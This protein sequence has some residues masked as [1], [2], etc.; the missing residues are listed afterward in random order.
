MEYSYIVIY[1]VNLDSMKSNFRGSFMKRFLFITITAGLLF[2]NVC[3]SQVSFVVENKKPEKVIK[4]TKNLKLYKPLRIKFNKIDSRFYLVDTHAPGVKVFDKN[5]K[6][7]KSIGSL[8]SAPGQFNLPGDV[9]FID[10][11]IIIVDSFNYRIQIFDMDMNYISSFKYGKYGVGTTEVFA[12][13]DSKGRIY[14]NTVRNGALFDVYDI[15]GNVIKS[16][17]ESLENKFEQRKNVKLDDKTHKKVEKIDKEL[18]NTVSYCIDENDDLFCVFNGFPVLRKYDSKNELVFEVSLKDIP[19]IQN[20]PD[21]SNLTS[22]NTRQCFNQLNLDEKYL[23]VCLALK[24][25]PLYILDKD[26]GKIL[27]KLYLKHENN[28]VFSGIDTSQDNFIYAVD[29]ENK[30]VLRYKK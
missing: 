13:V 4:S 24:D 25:S 26:T 14:L 16:F 28:T 17:G 2:S 5:F 18:L 15:E 11:K 7:L 6:F 3:F 12:P 8:G 27:K 1:L 9:S 22:R 21:K 10:D 20:I 29:S 30:T 23:Y 19:E